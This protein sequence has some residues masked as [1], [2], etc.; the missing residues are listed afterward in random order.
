MVARGDGSSREAVSCRL[1]PSL[2][3]R[4]CPKFIIPFGSFGHNW[5][6]YIIPSPCSPTRQQKMKQTHALYEG[7]FATSCRPTSPLL[8]HTT[9]SRRSSA[10]TTS[11]SEFD[12][13]YSQFQDDG[14]EADAKSQFG[15]KIYWEQMYE[16]MG[17]FPSDEYSWYYGW[18]GIKPH[19]LE[20]IDDDTSSKSEISILV[21]GCGNDP[22]LLDL[23]NAGYKQLTAFDY[24]SGAIDRQRELFEYLPMG[25]DL[26]NVELCVHDARTLPQEWEQSFDVIIEKGALDAIYLSGDGNFEK[27]V[28]ELARVV[29]KGGICISVSGV[30][31]EE[32]RREGF[33][34]DEW[35]WLRDGSDDLKAGCF[36]LK[37]T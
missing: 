19:F 10:F 15:T 23:Y 33:G 16:G 14:E 26:N 6:L 30:V 25:S 37:K 31:P 7:C 3:G 36:V 13:D 35:E 9:I 17:D 34:T 24:S 12:K 21:P 32:L 5:L 1:P 4:L 22:L 29:R 2:V 27:S 8:H 11:A 20:H 28:D 18:E